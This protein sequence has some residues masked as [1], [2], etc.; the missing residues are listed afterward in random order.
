MFQADAT[1]VWIDRNGRAQAQDYYL[2]GYVQVCFMIP[3]VQHNDYCGMHFLFSVCEYSVMGDRGH[4]LTR[5]I[6]Q[7]EGPVMFLMCLVSLKMGSSA[8]PSQGL[9]I[10]VSN[11]TNSCSQQTISLQLTVGHVT[12]LLIRPIRTSTLSG[13]LVHSERQHFNT[14]QEHQVCKVVVH[15]YIITIDFVI[16][17]SGCVIL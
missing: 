3:Y 9:S 7:L 4:V 6:L 1:M 15:Y 14:T 10:Q 2:S 16:V 17:L 12:I 5:W 13:A 11:F 8:F